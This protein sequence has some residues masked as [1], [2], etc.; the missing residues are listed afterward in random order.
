MKK[1]EFWE[2]IKVKGISIKFFVRKKRGKQNE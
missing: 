1:N 2:E